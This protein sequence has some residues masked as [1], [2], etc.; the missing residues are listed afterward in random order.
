MEMYLQGILSGKLLF[1]YL[2]SGP[3]KEHRINAS[4]LNIRIED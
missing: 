3:I 1:I 4:S 2:V